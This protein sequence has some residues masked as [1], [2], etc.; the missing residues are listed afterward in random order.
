[1]RLH[2]ALMM[3][4]LAAVSALPAQAHD[5][6]AGV[7]GF[8]GGLLHPLL[9]PA[10]LLALVAIGLLLGQET[11]RR[12][13][14]LLA[15]FAAS[16]AAGIV[17]IV[18]AFAVNDTDYAL[19]AVAAAAGVAVAVARPVPVLVTGPL[20][21]IAGAAIELDSV[22]QEISMLAT[23][24]AL[25]GTAVAAFVVTTLLADL[26]ARI[27]HGWLRIGVR[28]VGSWVAAVAILA[29]TLRLTR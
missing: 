26:T 17:V 28:I 4:L 12:R 29:L 10:H 8:Y 23:F 11:S 3:V 19:L 6:V 7:G 15:L 22:P 2:R 27:N 9:V 14:G 13:A 1:M 25:V 20:V 24:L 21:A 16:L 5:A 18:L